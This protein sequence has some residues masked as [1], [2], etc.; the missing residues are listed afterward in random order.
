MA[1]KAVKQRKRSRRSQV[2]L[3]AEDADLVSRLAERTGLPPREVIERA[4]AAYAAAV[5]PGM[6]VVPA[7]AG[8]RRRGVRKRLFVS[9]DGGP[10][11]EIKKS[12]FVFGRDPSSDIASDIPLVSPRHA[13]VLFRDGEPVFEDLQSQRGT[14]QHGQ[15]IDVK[16]IR[17][18]DEFDLGGFVTVRF[19][20]AGKDS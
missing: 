10:E 1:R 9:V 14:Y 4:L 13:R 6:P 19:R 12:E 16:A 11:I 15:K 17:D 8:S 3:R 7:P 18:G 2:S 20:V 5:A